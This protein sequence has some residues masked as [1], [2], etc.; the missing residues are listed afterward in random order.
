VPPKPPAGPP[1]TVPP[2]TPQAAY[3]KV[4]KALTTRTAHQSP[5]TTSQREQLLEAFRNDP[6]DL[7][8][9][10]QSRQSYVRAATFAGTTEG[11]AR[12]AWLRGWQ[13]APALKPIVDREKAMAR[14]INY[15]QDF[16]RR[17]AE[18]H[19][20]AVEDAAKQ[21]AIEAV[22]ARAASTYVS[23]LWEQLVPLGR[24]IMGGVLAFWSQNKPANAKEA[25]D[26]A[27]TLAYV[28]R[29]LTAVTSEA[30]QMERLVAGEPGAIVAVQEEALPQ[31]LDEV[32][33]ELEIVRE[34]LARDAARVPAPPQPTKN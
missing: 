7:E 17:L 20:D 33:A 19:A 12:R 6:P 8:G 28:A 29:S 2:V 26:R 9:T 4:A 14:A 25:G 31:T 24:T 15:R 21:R 3:A 32:N 5:L 16:T 13:D 10:R 23:S 11:K 27:R 30:Q 1:A 34:A 18:V 22:N